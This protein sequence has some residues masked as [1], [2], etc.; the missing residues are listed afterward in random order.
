MPPKID[1]SEPWNPLLCDYPDSN[2]IN[3]VSIGAEAMF[4]RLLARS[5]DNG[6]YDACPTLL[7][8]NL[9]AKR[10]KNRTVT[11]KKVA[12]WR[13]EL[14]AVGLIK[15]YQ[16]GGEIYLNIVNCKKHLRGDIKPKIK[17]PEFS[18]STAI[19]TLT[20][21]VTD[22]LRTRN[23]NVPSTTTT[24]TTTTTL[25]SCFENFW[26][27]Y[28]KCQRKIEKAKCRDWWLAKKLDANQIDRLMQALDIDKKSRDWTK[29]TGAFIPLP[30]T[31][32][33][34]RRWED[35][36]ED[37]KPEPAAK[38]VVK[39]ACGTPITMRNANGVPEK[40]CYECRN[41]NHKENQAG[42]VHGD[43]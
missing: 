32:L 29:D 18:Q 9:Y 8:C 27:T 33:N 16:T 43:E 17:Y 11:A 5:D 40:Q 24:T 39:C 2:K 30:M 26:K 7:L 15:L 35:T 36:L 3:Q 37:N 23:E 1:K 14:A 13:D 42:S 31:W 34:K 41:K 6:N 12:A 22:T 38:R 20:V 4:T 21:P 10:Y 19:T 25:L 28:P